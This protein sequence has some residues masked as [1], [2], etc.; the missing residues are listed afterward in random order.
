MDIQGHGLSL[1]PNISISSK[2][3]IT[4]VQ[5]ATGSVDYL[6]FG[7]LCRDSYT[8]VIRGLIENQFLDPIFIPV[9]L[10]DE[11]LPPAATNCEEV[12]PLPQHNADAC[13]ILLSN[14]NQWRMLHPL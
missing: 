14:N 13:N 3:I 9:V 11:T 7:W 2:E 12:T 4:L 5:I 1:I 10:I 8:E 6:L